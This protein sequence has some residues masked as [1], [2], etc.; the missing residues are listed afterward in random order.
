MD[1]GAVA[2]DG[3]GG[4]VSIR[5]GYYSHLLAT[6]Q[7]NMQKLSV[8]V[9]DC[10]LAQLGPFE[11]VIF[12]WRLRV[13]IWWIGASGQMKNTNRLNTGGRVVWRMM[14]TRAKY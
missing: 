2:A 7:N 4:S 1:G 5:H 10:Q 12:F 11:G 6:T 3:Q 13:E 9:Q 14:E 8:M